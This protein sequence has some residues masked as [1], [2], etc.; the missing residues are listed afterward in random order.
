MKRQG[1]KI[2]L[3][4]LAQGV[5]R[6]FSGTLALRRQPET[7][8]EFRVDVDHDRVFVAPDTHFLGPLHVTTVPVAHVLV[9]HRHLMMKDAVVLFVHLPLPGVGFPSH[10]FLATLAAPAGQETNT[11]SRGGFVVDDE[12]GIAL[13][14]ARPIRLRE[15]GQLEAASQFDQDLLKGLAF[16]FRWQDGN[17]HCV[18]RA[19]EFGNRPIQHG[20][21]VMAF[22]IRRVRQDQIGECRHLRLESITDDQERNLVLTD[23][24]AL[25]VL[26]I[27][28]L[29]NFRGVHGG[30]PRH[31]RHEY[32]QGVNA[33]GITAPSVGDDVVHQA[34][35]G[36]GVLPGKSLVDTHRLALIVHKQVIRTFGPTQRCTVQRCVRLD[37]LGTLGRT[38]VRRYGAWVGRLVPKSAGSVDG[39][40]Q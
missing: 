4:P 7:L 14:L 9:F 2:G 38:G 34:M 5:R 29:A 15:C 26:V 19:V 33:I 3:H 20:H 30:I 1:I 39:A 28:H 17:P 27:E 18:N 35:G 32:Q 8:Q 10:R 16:T 23:L 37:G 13:E 36:Q 31:V 12:V 11:G 21:A 40:Q 22:K 24:F 25:S 6:L